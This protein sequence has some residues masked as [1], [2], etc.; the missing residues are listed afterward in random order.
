VTAAATMCLSVST[1][2]AAPLSHQSFLL[3]NLAIFFSQRIAREHEI[4]V[5]DSNGW[6]QSVDWFEGPPH[7]LVW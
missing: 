3:L 5:A 2:V 4:S 6:P 1:R 7:W